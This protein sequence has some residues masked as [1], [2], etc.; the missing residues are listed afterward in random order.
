MY[1]QNGS[2]LQNHKNP[3]TVQLKILPPRA[4]TP[5]NGTMQKRLDEKIKKPERLS[6]HVPT[7]ETNTRNEM[8]SKISCKV[9]F[10]YFPKNPVQ[11]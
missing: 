10:Q 5:S 11:K 1:F 6:L 9:N 2:K 7:K 4:C 3:E 8:T